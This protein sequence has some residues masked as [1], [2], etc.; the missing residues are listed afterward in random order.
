ML[1]GEVGVVVQERA[2]LVLVS[3][4]VCNTHPVIPIPSLF[5]SLLLSSCLCCLKWKAREQAAQSWC[6]DW[7]QRWHHFR[8]RGTRKGSCAGCCHSLGH[9]HCD[10]AVG[11]GV[12]H[13]ELGMGVGTRLDPVVNIPIYSLFSSL[14]SIVSITFL[15]S[16]RSIYLKHAIYGYIPTFFP[17]KMPFI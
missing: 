7:A 2:G 13:A 15:I 1:E 6:R 11:R 8:V 10:R 16:F 17:L 5:P 12:A 14:L 3:N 4:W 9:T